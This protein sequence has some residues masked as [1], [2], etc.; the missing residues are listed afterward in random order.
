MID[1]LFLTEVPNWAVL[2]IAAPAFLQAA[3]WIAALV[4]VLLGADK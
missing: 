3:V 1:W 4:I 2:A